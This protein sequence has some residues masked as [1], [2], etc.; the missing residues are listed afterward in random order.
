MTIDRLVATARRLEAEMLVLTRRA[1]RATHD[2]AAMIEPGLTILEYGVLEHLRSHGA[3]RA[4]TLVETLCADKGAMS[5]AIQGLLDAR[6]VE[7]T[8]DPEDGRAL[9]VGLTD[10]ARERLAAMAEQRRTGFL[11]RFADWE[12]A[13]LDA[14]VDLLARYNATLER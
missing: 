5:R 12:P 13:E 4:S 14:F 10:L 3:A 6:L 8:P 9:Q 1:R 7:R 2:R 11:A